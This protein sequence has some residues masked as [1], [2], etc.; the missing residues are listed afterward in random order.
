[1][2]SAAIVVA[3]EVVEAAV[4][5]TEHSEDNASD[6]DSSVVDTEP[7]EDDHNLAPLDSLRLDASLDNLEGA[8][9]AVV[10]A[11]AAAAAAVEEPS[12]VAVAATVE[13][14][15]ALQWEAFGVAWAEKAPFEFASV[16]MGA[17]D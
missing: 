10:V 4:V 11:A 13:V 9:V 16:A 14:P 2:R 1:M 17:I 12:A 7:V 6:V 3:A 15:V 5:A 8:V